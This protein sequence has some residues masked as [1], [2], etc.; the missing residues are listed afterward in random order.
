MQSFPCKSGPEFFF[1]TDV[2]DFVSGQPWKFTNHEATTPQ[3]FF[4]AITIQLS[5][6]NN[7]KKDLQGVLSAEMPNAGEVQRRRR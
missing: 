5:A 3:N 1:P 6:K 2:E 4:C 7:L